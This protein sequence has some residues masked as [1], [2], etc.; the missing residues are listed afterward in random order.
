MAMAFAACGCDLT[1]QACLH[2]STRTN[3]RDG[4]SPKH[5]WRTRLNNAPLVSATTAVA[6]A[7]PAARRSVIKTL[8]VER[9]QWDKHLV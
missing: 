5:A 1:C 4:T 9:S 7:M 8:R 3:I 6:Q 2:P